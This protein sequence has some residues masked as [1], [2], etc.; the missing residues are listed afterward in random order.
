MPEPLARASRAL[1]SAV[2]FLTCRRFGSGCLPGCDLLGA[3]R[4]SEET[5]AGSGLTAPAR[6]A[7]RS[8]SEASRQL[9]FSQDLAR[10]KEEISW[11]HDTQRGGAGE[12]GSEL[13]QRLER[14]LGSSGAREQ[15]SRTS[16]GSQP[17]G[18]L[19]TPPRFRMK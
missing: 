3:G 14:E 9:A 15:E 5:F 7:R 4:H 18:E 16:H 11:C 10:E 12:A 6:A 8:E 1:G 17:L 19:G 2:P 13:T